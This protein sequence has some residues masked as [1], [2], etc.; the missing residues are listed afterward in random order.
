MGPDF[1]GELPNAKLKSHEGLWQHGGH[2]KREHLSV[3]G[4]LASKLLSPFVVGGM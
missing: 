2:C 3:F 4:A 1:Q